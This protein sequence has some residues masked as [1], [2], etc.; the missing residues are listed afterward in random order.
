[1]SSPPLFK[2][3]AE[4]AKG[5]VRCPPRVK[6][7]DNLVAQ[8]KLAIRV[9]DKH[10]H[11]AARQDQ[12]ITE[13]KARAQA[14]EISQLQKQKARATQYPLLSQAMAAC[15]ELTL[16]NPKVEQWAKKAIAKIVRLH[17]L[18]GHDI[19]VTNNNAAPPMQS[20][21][22]QTTVKQNGSTKP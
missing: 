21:S 13:S 19:I 5:L 10:Q 20:S 8:L 2:S 12:V 22:L 6:L 9:H 7:P 1:M 15:E 18:A 17:R 3:P 11:A 4:Q 16:S 14:K